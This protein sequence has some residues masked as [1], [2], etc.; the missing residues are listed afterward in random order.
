MAKIKYAEVNDS[1][2][3]VGVHNYEIP[4]G[5]LPTGYTI[6]DIEGVEDPS[7]LVGQNVSVIPETLDKRVVLNQLTDAEELRLQLKQLSIELDLQARLAEDT[8]ATQ[9]EF[10][11]LKLAYEAL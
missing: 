9:A 11:A 1:N 5:S 6:V 10:D 2:I 3:I 8:T 7:G 4:A